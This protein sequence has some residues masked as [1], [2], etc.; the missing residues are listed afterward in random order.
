MNQNNFN[1][2]KTYL[3]LL[4]LNKLYSQTYIVTA[5]DGIGNTNTDDVIVKVN[6]V[7]ANAGSDRT[8]SEGENI[9]LTATGGDNYLWSNGET[10]ATISVSPAVT[11][12]YTV[13]V[14]QGN[15]QDSDN[16]VANAG[17]DR[18]ILEGESITLVAI[19]GDSYI[20]NTGEKSSSISVNPNSTRTY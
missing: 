12:V 11:T 4:I 19:G 8:I 14:S 15:C 16:I 3:P 2:A 5:R 13:T 10:T 1:C 7:T 9:S 18:T 17:L 20:W 6:S